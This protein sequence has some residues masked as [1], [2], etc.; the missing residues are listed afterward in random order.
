MSLQNLVLMLS[1]Y[2]E[3]FHFDPLDMCFIAIHP[4]AVEIFLSGPKQRTEPCR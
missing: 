3:I 2:V 4:I 1:E